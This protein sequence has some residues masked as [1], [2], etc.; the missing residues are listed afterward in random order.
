MDGR[1]LAPSGDEGEFTDIENIPILAVQRMDILPDSAT[2]LYGAGA[3]GGV[4]NF[5]MRDNFTGSES[6]ARGLGHGEHSEG[7]P[8]RSD[9]GK[10]VGFGQCHAIGGI[11]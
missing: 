8:S 2:A 4:V 9:V 6:F 7:I 3:V 1:R 11:L 10:A 5:V